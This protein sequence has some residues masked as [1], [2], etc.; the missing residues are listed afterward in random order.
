MQKIPLKRARPGMILAT[1][2]QRD[3][4]LVL[5]GPDTELTEHIIHRLMLSGVPTITVQ[6]HPAPDEA[7][8]DYGTLLEALDPMFRHLQEDRFMST[9]QNVI[10]SYFLAKQ[11][12]AEAQ[13]AAEAAKNKE[14]V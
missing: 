8:G 12:E 14:E 1:P 2:V 6:G 3:D 4:G 11:T 13:K 5:V 10:R 9:L 7:G